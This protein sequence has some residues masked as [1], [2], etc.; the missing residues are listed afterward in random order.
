MA[1]A[2]EGNAVPLLR[3][4]LHA[5]H[6]AHGGRLVPFAGWEMP[7]QYRGIVAE[8]EACR[9]AC[10]LF[11]V[12]HMGR[13]DFGGEGVGEF[14]DQLVTRRVAGMPA[15]RIRY[16]LV[17]REDG[18]ILD[19]VLVYHL[20]GLDGTARYSMVVNAGNREKLWDWFVTRATGAGRVE[21]RDRTVETAMIAVQGPQGIAIASRWL[22]WDPSALPYYGGRLVKVDGAV[23]TVSRTGYTGED[24]V[25]LMVPGERAESVWERL[26]QLG[27]ADG[28]M[29]AGLGARDTLRL[30]AAM[31]LY[32]HEL[33]E[34]IQAAW[35]GLEFAIQT[36]GRDF[37][38]REAYLRVRATGTHPVRVGL[39]LEGKRPAR[40]G[41]TVFC[42]GEKVGE[43][44]SGTFSPTLQ[45][46]IAMGYVQPAVAGLGT[47]VEIDIRGALHPATV[48]ALPFYR[49]GN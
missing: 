33:S 19:D 34:T 8:H 14:L 28:V 1:E 47:S 30:E 31:P 2:I 26:L 17:C 41:A 27:A 48:V 29:A 42:R 7:V 11:D 40:E 39:Q 3:T 4:P 24:G 44:T 20:T 18:G 12:S 9:T 22:G 45:V 13:F 32:G 21:L 38:G 43:V 15:D 10:A 36:E 6:A 23:I 37:V 35:T 25:E 5:W 49:R 46:P 16:G